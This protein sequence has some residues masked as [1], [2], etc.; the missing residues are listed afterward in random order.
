MKCGESDGRNDE[1]S[2]NYSAEKFFELMIPKKTPV[3]IDIGAHKGESV[4][5]FSSIFPNA[6]IY[7]AEPD[8][9]SYAELVKYLPDASKAINAAVAAEDGTASFFQYDKSHLNSLHAINKDSKDS[10]GYAEKTTAIEVKVRCVTL[11]TL[12]DELGIADKRIDLLKIDAQ[13]GELEILCGAKNSLEK[14]DN[15]T[16]ELNLF[17]F[18]NKRNT[19]FE[20]EQLLPDFE[21]YAI[22]K[23]SQNPKNF[24]TDWAEVFYRRKS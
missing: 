20:I 13:G 4:M 9:V 18:Y 16:L 21:L 11:D 10:L 23:L 15:I 8:P 17:D 14:V 19:F 24:R 3:I 7:S 1:Y 12:T 6:E 5:F 2:D 22:T